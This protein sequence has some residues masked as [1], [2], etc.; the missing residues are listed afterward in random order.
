MRNLLLTQS[1]IVTLLNESSIPSE[2]LS[3]NRVP[4]VFFCEGRSRIDRKQIRVGEGRN[5]SA[6]DRQGND[7]ALSP[8]L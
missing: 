1:S 3:R 8:V 6:R 4:E 5:L 2:K 7:C